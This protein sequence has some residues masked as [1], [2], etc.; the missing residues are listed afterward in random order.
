MEEIKII[1]LPEKP[2]IQATNYLIAEDEDG[3]KRVLAKHFRSLLVSS[4]YFNNVEDLKNSVSASLKEGDIVQ[5]LG[6]H[7]PGDGGGAIYRITY[8]PRIVEDSGLVHY[9]SYSDTLRAEMVL[10]DSVNVHQFGA[11]GD[12]VTD[13]TKAIQAAINNATYKIIEFNNNKTY[14]IRSTITINQNNV[15]LN[16]N[17]ATLCP[18]YCD[19][20]NISPVKDINETPSDIT[21]N[22]LRIDCNSAMSAGIIIHGSSKIDITGCTLF[23][24]SSKGIIIK[25]SEFINISFC[26]LSGRNEGSLIVFDENYEEGKFKYNRFINI[27]DCDFDSFFRAIHLSTLGKELEINSSVNID[28]CNY[29]STVDTAYCISIECPVDIVSV[30]S[31]TVTNADTFLR[32]TGANRGDITCRDISCIDTKYVF[33]IE[34]ANGVLYLDGTIKVD[35]HYNTVM[36]NRMSG[37]LHSKISWDLIPNGASFPYLPELK[38]VTGEIYDVNHPYN[39][40]EGKGYFADSS[41]LVITEARNL[42]VDWNVSGF[43]LRAIANGVKGQ[44]IYLKSS[45]NMSLHNHYCE[46][47][48]EIIRLGK[49]KGVILRFDGNKWNQ[50]QYYDSTILQTIEDQINVLVDYER[51]KLTPDELVELI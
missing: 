49:Y 27:L 42:H 13:D 9:L 20:I 44:L 35:Y 26:K 12:G 4:L 48:E 15:I 16:G 50:I 40:D 6:Y 18:L 11:V 30:Y 39:Y 14:L 3:T 34:T 45:T 23:N 21:V 1:E 41:T 43:D 19:G 29:N 25:N 24:V 38:P 2:S 5:T 10:G 7:E 8:N 51:I 36:F 47:S 31:N 37:K 17:G 32:F 46:L 22:K 33:D 28:K